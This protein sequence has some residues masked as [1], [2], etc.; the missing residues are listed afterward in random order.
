MKVVINGR[1]GG[2]GLS[3]IGHYELGRRLGLT[4]EQSN[5]VYADDTNRTNPD[6]VAMVE[7]NSS[8][9]SSSHAKLYVVEIPDDVEWYI[10]DYDGLEHIAEKHRTWQ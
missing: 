2:F 1:Y 10:H 4:T 9:Y 7:E 5:M 6:L 3:D 8:L